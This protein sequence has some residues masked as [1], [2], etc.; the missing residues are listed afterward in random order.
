[1]SVPA[2]LLAIGWLIRDTFR[3]AQASGIFWLMLGVTVLCILLCLSVAVEGDVSL[4]D[5]P[6]DRPEAL[7]RSDVYRA[8]AAVAD[9]VARGATQSAGVWPVPLPLYSPEYQ[10]V[11]IA[12]RHGVPVVRGQLKLAFGAISVDIARDRLHAVRSLQAVLAGWVADAAGLL[13]ALMWT[14]GF[15]PSFLEPGAVSVLLAKP[16]PRW[17]LLAGK[18]LGVL[19]FVAFQGLIFVAGTWFALALRT[20]VWDPRYFLCLP[21]LVLHF[22]VFF[23]FSVLLA[24][25]TRSAVVC[26][27]G[28]V[29]FW[30][31]CWGMNFGRHAALSLSGVEG[32]RSFGT[33]SE[34][35]YWMLPKPLDFHLILVQALQ[36]GDLVHAAVKVDQLAERGAWS[37]ELSVLASVLAGVVL[38]GLSAY[39]FVKADY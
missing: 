5:S 6:R 2:A 4:A 33:A 10:Q 14:A 35:A 13:L 17:S 26:A 27:F 32:L 34:V 28:S 16:A 22:A 1:M 8:S 23:S 21:L 37:P 30:L 25:S 19:V 9:I 7:P 36:A 20:G 15:L 18:Y 29:L 11:V 3:Q 39:E 24:V 38:L 12:E 31:V